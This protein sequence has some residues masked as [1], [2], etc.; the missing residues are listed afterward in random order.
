MRWGEVLI[1]LD[2]YRVSRASS[3]NREEWWIELSGGNNRYYISRTNCLFWLNLYYYRNMRYTRSWWKKWPRIKSANICTSALVK[4]DLY[5]RSIYGVMYLYH[6]IYDCVAKHFQNAK[7]HVIPVTIKPS[8][9]RLC[10]WHSPRVHYYWK[11]WKEE[12]SVGEKLL[13]S[14]SILPRSRA[15]SFTR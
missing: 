13:D 9:E 7:T 2:L 5:V 1:L 8:N 6:R 11:L 14:W 10:V 15:L 4:A 12:R 3:A